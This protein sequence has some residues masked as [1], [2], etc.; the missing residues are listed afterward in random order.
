MSRNELFDRAEA[1]TP[2][3]TRDCVCPCQVRIQ[4]S[5]QSDT[6]AL[7]LQLVVHAGVIAPECAHTND[8]DV[9]WV[10]DCQVS[11]LDHGI[12]ARFNHKWAR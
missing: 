8:G 1:T 2:E 10:L 9:Y 3:L 4:Y 11:V 6:F 12:N 7:L 5:D